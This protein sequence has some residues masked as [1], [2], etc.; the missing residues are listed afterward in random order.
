MENHIIKPEEKKYLRELAKK[1]LEISGLPVMGERLKAWT[2]HNDL[3]G[4]RPMIWF[5][6]HTVADP[7][8]LPVCKCETPEA[9]NIEG[10]LLISIFN[11]ERIGDDTV[12]TPDFRCFWNSSFLPFDMPVKKTRAKNS[13]GY[14]IEDQISDLSEQTDLI[15]HSTMTFDR[16]SSLTWFEFVQNLLGDILNVRM[17]SNGF[18]CVLTNDIVHRMGMENMLVNMLTC[19]DEFHF[20]MDRLSDDYIKYFDTLEKQ[21]MLCLNNGNDNVA[22]GTFGFSS[23]LP[24]KDF[25]ESHIRT[26]DLWGFLDSQETVGISPQQYG[27]FIFP[28]YKKVAGKY[29]LLSYGCCEPVNPIWSDCLSKLDNLRKVSISPWCDEEYMGQQ[30][31]NSNVIYQRKPSP[32]FVGEGDTLDEAAFREHIRH[33]LKCASGCKLEITFRDVYRLNGDLEKP[34]RAVEIVRQEIEEHWR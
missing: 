27:E 14:H 9:R 29:G 33:T 18:Y 19:P 25:N 3:K 8:F 13:E 5:E 30:L 7:G 21:N 34:R 32:L 11:H 17:A 15:K 22:Q 12:V 10:Q 2:D 23:Q 28:Y 6:P 31:K 4:K 16:D 24:P 1:K 26:T 20:M